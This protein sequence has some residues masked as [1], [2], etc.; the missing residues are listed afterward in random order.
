MGFTAMHDADECGIWS[1]LYELA[2]VTDL[3]VRVEKRQIIIGDCIK[4][5]CDFF[6]INS[7]AFYQ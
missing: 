7:Y 6:G 3:S 2:Q 4:K 5:I 1:D